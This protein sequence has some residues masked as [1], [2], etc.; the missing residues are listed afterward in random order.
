MNMA[1][2]LPNPNPVVIS[3]GQ[4]KQVSDQLRGYTFCDDCEQ[5]LSDKGEKWVL[6]NVPEDQGSP[7]P[8]QDALIPEK[9][10]FING[11]FN[12]YEG[13]KIQAFNMDQLIY[14]GMSIF[15]RGAA[16]EWKS[17]LGG[18]APSV[19]LGKQYEPMRQFLLGGPFPDDV[20]I[21]VLIHNLKP[22]MNIATTVMKASHQ[23]ADYYWFYLNGLGYKLYLGKNIPES[24]RQPAWLDTL[25]A[26]RSPGGLGM[27]DRGFGEMV[28]EF[29]RT[30]VMS[31]EL[32]PK[33][34]TF[35]KGPDP[36]KKSLT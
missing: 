15:W 16:R 4:L 2:S 29:A 36:R 18:I 13:R 27:V 10:L 26:Y 21:F 6:A 35:L 12:M 14:F 32:S 3:H 7:F 24:I 1:K 9:P 20:V 25:C 23:T 30:A 28:R 19:D 17:S 34:E 22:V 11:D 5:M 8:L 33:L 31:S